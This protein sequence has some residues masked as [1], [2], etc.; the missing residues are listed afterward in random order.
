VAI[1]RAEAQAMRGISGWLAG[2][3][4][5]LA[6]ALAAVGHAQ[7][8][9]DPGS[10]EAKLF[11]CKTCHGQSGQ[12]FH[13]YIPI[14]RLAG[15]PQQYIEN[16]LS[17]FVEGRRLHPIMSRVAKSFGP[18]VRSALAA[19]FSRIESGPLGGGPGRSP[20]IGRQLYESGIP[21]NN[22][23][24]CMVCHG[25][26][27]KGQDEIPR[28]AGQLYEYTVIQLVDWGKY[29]GFGLPPDLALVMTP[30]AHNL[31]RAQIEAVA[32]Y[33]SHLH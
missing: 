27:A 19:H 16:Q 3:A 22:V 33:V 30:T 26:R 1:G 29:R 8:A 4:A 6:A 24:A 32:A 2:W 18:G 7:E 31:T 23:P 15:Q 14:P 12:G 13:G 25:D 9:P 28:L 10:F 21:D 5:L 20:E 11:Y 17:A